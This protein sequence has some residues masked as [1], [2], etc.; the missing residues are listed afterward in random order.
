MMRLLKSL[1]LWCLCLGFYR[2]N[3]QEFQLSC[4]QTDIGLFKNPIFQDSMLVGLWFDFEGAEIRYTLDGSLPNNASPLYRESIVIQ[5][6]AT[7]TAISIHPDYR[8]SDPVQVQFIQTF[9]ELEPL[10]AYLTQPS[11]ALY[12]GLGVTTLLDQEKGHADLSSGRW[13]GF[14]GKNL[15]YTLKLNQKEQ[16][17]ALVVSTLSAPGSWIFPPRRIEIRASRHK[18]RG[19]RQ[20]AAFDLQ[21]SDHPSNEEKIYTLPLRKHRA[22]YWRVLVQHYGPLPDWHPGKGKPA[23]LFVDEILLQR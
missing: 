19:F 16:P 21:A 8:S 3:A 9:D 17:G 7:L 23:W 1:I 13:L 10:E 4:P 5:K 12:P 6:S 18:K 22:R 15:E 14:E 20:I 2:A 11:S